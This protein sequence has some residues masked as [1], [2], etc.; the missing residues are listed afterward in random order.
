M[1]FLWEWLLPDTEGLV[2]AVLPIA[3]VVFYVVMILIAFGSLV[4]IVKAIKSKTVL[5]ESQILRVSNSIYLYGYL[6]LVILT[7]L[8]L[9]ASPIFEAHIMFPVY[10]CLTTLM[11]MGLK[12]LWDH[13]E[14]WVK[15]FA[16]VLALGISLIFAEGTY[17]SGREISW[18]GQGFINAGWLNSETLAAMRKLPEEM[19]IYSNKIMAIQFLNDRP[20]FALPSPINPA[21]DRPREGYE[22]NVLS[23]REKV[24]N[25]EAYMVVFNYYGLLSSNNAEDVKMMEDLGNGMPILYDLYDGVIFGVDLQ[26]EKES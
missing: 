9:D 19:P 17:Y 14:K 11:I 1:Q 18:G 15:A 24:L 2:A 4:W 21:T 20:A 8:F 22:E 10:V 25:G 26:D 7:L 13:N 5:S 16:V 23:V 3:S 6:V 12:W